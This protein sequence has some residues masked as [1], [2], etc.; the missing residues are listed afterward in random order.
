MRIAMTD[1]GID[2]LDVIHAGTSTFLLA[3]GI[4]AVAATRVLEDVEKL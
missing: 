3:P 4:R 1:L 2:S